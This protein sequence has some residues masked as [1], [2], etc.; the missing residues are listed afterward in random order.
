MTLQGTLHDLCL[1]AHGRASEVGS[2]PGS[3][4]K[5]VG[6]RVENLPTCRVQ[7]KSVLIYSLPLWQAVASRYLTHKSF[8]LAP[9]PFL[10]SRTD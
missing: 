2:G 10:I 5:I 9:K 8:Q 1:H 6:R 3:G 4:F 7:R